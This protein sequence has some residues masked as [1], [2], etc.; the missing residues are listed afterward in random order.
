[1][2]FVCFRCAWKNVAVAE[3]E[4]H[5]RI[6]RCL[7]YT[8]QHDEKIA[9]VEWRQ[10]CWVNWAVSTI[11]A[12]FIVWLC[13]PSYRAKQNVLRIWWSTLCRRPIWFH[14][15]T[16]FCCKASHAE[17]STPLKST[18]LSARFLFRRAAVRG[19]TGK[20]SWHVN[21]ECYFGVR[22]FNC[23]SAKYLTMWNWTQQFYS[24]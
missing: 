7:L 8:I 15:D 5:I 4:C 24:L 21:D 3:R 19:S 1:M 14:D 12:P 18:L 23:T 16:I 11:M 17:R 2:P 20:W 9:S 13:I 22:L 6:A 10:Y